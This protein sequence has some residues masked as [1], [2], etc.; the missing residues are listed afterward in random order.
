VYS[1]KRVHWL[2]ARAQKDR[3][4]EEVILVTYEMQWTVRYFLQRSKTW[5]AG[6]E[7][8]NV[9]AGAKAYALRQGS[10]WKNLADVADNV[11]KNTTHLYLSP[12][13]IDVIIM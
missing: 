10:L 2:R 7:S 1:V 6:A 4:H 13:S 12:Y 9:S 11:F 5:E 8:V 3:W